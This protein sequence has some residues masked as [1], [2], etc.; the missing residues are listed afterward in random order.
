MATTRVLVQTCREMLQGKSSYTVSH[1]ERL[2]KCYERSFP[3]FSNYTCLV[4][5]CRET[6]Q[7]KSSYTVSNRERL[8]KS[9]ERSFPRFS[10]NT[11]SVL[12]FH[13]WLLKH[14]RVYQFSSEHLT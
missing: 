13:C 3:R 4:Q 6:L 7:A 12:Q 11:I 1:R 8:Q 10:T 5:T 2:Q 14:P 9:Y